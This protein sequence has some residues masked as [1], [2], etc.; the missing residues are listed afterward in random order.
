[1]LRWI[2]TNDNGVDNAIEEDEEDEE[3]DA[4][5]DEDEEEEEPEHDEAKSA[6]ASPQSEVKDDLV[7]AIRSRRSKPRKSSRHRSDWMLMGLALMKPPPVKA[8]RRNSNVAKKRAL[9]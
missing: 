7:L 6:A 8:A 1:M 2:T 9:R 3:D 4:V 5:A